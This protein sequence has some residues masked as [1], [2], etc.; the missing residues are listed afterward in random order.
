[1]T[2]R[3]RGVSALAYAAVAVLVGVWRFLQPDGGTTGLYFGLAIGAI[4]AA[5]GGLL[6]RGKRLAGTVTCFVAL[7]FGG[8]FFVHRI[9]SGGAEGDLPRAGLAVAA[10]LALAIVLLLPERSAARN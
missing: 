3:I 9:V 8:G 5:G 7:V 6:I 10:A 4:A 1:M 2:S